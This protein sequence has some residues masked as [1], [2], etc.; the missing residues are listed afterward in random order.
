MSDASPIAA[1]AIR[2][3]NVDAGDLDALFEIQCDPDA[4]LMAAVIPRSREK[5]MEVWNS[6]L[7][8]P[9]VVAKVI[10]L[11]GRLVGSIS[12]FSRDGVSFIGYWIDR[13]YWGRG[14]A[15]HALALLL[16]LLPERPLHARVAA[17][18]AASLRVLQKYGFEIVSTEFAPANERFLACEEVLLVLR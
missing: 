3:R 5:F 18:N 13:A 1:D 15:S 11:D 9:E 2:L 6:V 7:A 16:P 8:D 17:H 4:N 10:V 12:R 14:I